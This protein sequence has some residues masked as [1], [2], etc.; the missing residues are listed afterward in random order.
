VNTTPIPP[1][2]PLGETKPTINPYQQAWRLA[3]NRLKW[4]LGPESRR[5]RQILRAW[6]DRH[7]GK[8]AVILCNGPSLL[9]SD[10]SLLDGVFTFGLNK[11]NLLFETSSFRPS[12]IVAVNGLVIEQNADFYNRTELP[13]FLDSQHRRWVQPR[14]NVAFLHSSAHGRFARDVSV[15]IQQGFTVTYVAMQLAFHMGFRDVALIGCDHNFASKGP[16]N[17]TVVSGEKDAS[18]FDP[19]YFSGGQKWQLPDL[20]AS[21]YYYS[22]AAEVYQ[23]F[24]GRIVNCTVGGKLEQFPRLPLEDWLQ[25][26]GA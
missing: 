8:K 13:I 7:A 10:L 3:V 22:V 2:S 6:Q 4:D 18:H 15:S 24:N 20:A 11:I 12:C 16:A 1:K 5:S 19:R 26:P 23:A 9:K 25:S 14:S 21:E 17:Q